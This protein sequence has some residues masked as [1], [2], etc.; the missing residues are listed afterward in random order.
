MINCVINHEYAQHHMLYLTTYIYTEQW[1]ENHY[2][3]GDGK[4]C[5]TAVTSSNSTANAQLRVLVNKQQTQ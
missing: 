4:M 3:I 2:G 5:A 1:R